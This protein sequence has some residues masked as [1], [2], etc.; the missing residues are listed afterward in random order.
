M[1]DSERGSSGLGDIAHVRSDGER[2][3]RF[4]RGLR[5]GGGNCG[6]GGT[7]ACEEVGLE[8]LNR[9]VRRLQRRKSANVALWR[10]QNRP[11]LLERLLDGGLAELGSRREAVDRAAVGRS[12]ACA[13]VRSASV[14]LHASRSAA[15][16]MKSAWRACVRPRA[17]YV[18]R[19]A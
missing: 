4:C 14:F 18:P 6:A 19:S 15:P 5:L 16:K 2:G 3:R 9:A 8:P 13:C 12:A 1:D 10:G 17:Q 7:A 11:H